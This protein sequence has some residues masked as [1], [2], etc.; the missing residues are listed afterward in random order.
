MIR[1]I[2][3][4]VVCIVALWGAYYA[5]GFDTIYKKFFKE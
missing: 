2:L 5:P 3:G 1:T 4:I